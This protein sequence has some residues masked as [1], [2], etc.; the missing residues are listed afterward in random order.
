[1][2]LI[3]GRKKDAARLFPLVASERTRHNE[4]K[5]KYRK[6]YLNIRFIYFYPFPPG[7][8][9]ELWNKFAQRHFE[10]IQNSAGYDLEQSAVV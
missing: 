8:V 1:M 10:D 6:F 3:G 2:Y 9:I 4:H 5:L 7:R